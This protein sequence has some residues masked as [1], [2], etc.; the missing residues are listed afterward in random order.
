MDLEIPRTSAFTFQS[1]V[2]SLHVLRCLDD[3]RQKEILCDVT[4]LVEN[5]SYRAHRSV[6]AA[7]SDYFHNRVSGHAWQGL[8]ITLPE[9]VTVEGF[10]PLLQ[11]AYTAK[12]LFTKENIVEIH[13]CAEILGFHNLDKACF[14][15]LI[16]KFFD[17]GK[18]VH[19]VQRKVC[20]KTK[21]CKR[22][23]SQANSR[24]HS[25]RDEPEEEHS[26]AEPSRAVPKNRSDGAQT[27]S[28]VLVSE[29]PV[30]CVPGYPDTHAETDY[31][32]LCP[33]YRKF[34]VACEKDRFCLEDCGP[35]MTPFPPALTSQACASPCLPC[36]RGENN[37]GAGDVCS[38]PENETTPLANCL[39]CTPESSTST[40][41]LAT[42][43]LNC[44][45]PAGPSSAAPDRCP[46]GPADAVM[47]Q[48][49]D[50]ALGCAGNEGTV[51]FE[52]TDSALSVLGHE[53]GGDR[54]SVERE[55]AEHLAKGF[56][57]DPPPSQ[58]EPLL[59]DPES[60]SSLGKETDFHWLKHLDL[61]ASTGDCPFLRDLGEEVQLPEFEGGAQPEKSPCISSVNSGDNSDSDTDGDS[62]C[63][64]SER[65]RE[66]QLPFPVEQIP[67]LS[68]NDF[69]HMLR[70]QNL[71]REQ[72]DFVHDVRRRS[73]N[74]IAAQ[75]C[76]KR[77]LE[78][79]LGLEGEIHKLRSEKEKLVQE[80]DQLKRR[81]G[82]T[83]HSLSELCHK[84]CSEATL[85]PDQLEF[86]AQYSSP[87]CP[88]SVLITPTPSPALSLRFSLTLQDQDPTSAG[89]SLD[90]CPSEDP[91]PSA[92]ESRITPQSS[93]PS[94]PAL[95][96]PPPPPPVGT[97]DC[98]AP[99][100]NSSSPITDICLDVSG[101]CPASEVSQSRTP[102]PFDLNK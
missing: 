56:W 93:R 26:D 20:C 37:D 72:L 66:M 30:A 45:Q 12:L 67:S 89:I 33:K 51:N 102:L 17:H 85:S 44:D 4:I 78:C 11:F 96:P 39:S 8:V 58:G 19:R 80:R 2:H 75:R 76:R 90:A 28:S 84:V 46:V 54:S 98:S 40:G 27:Q 24:S 81:K 34:Q 3:Q 91:S 82:E 48:D 74:R 52:P 79:I 61:N 1:S 25:D 68:R 64:N 99:D 53:G 87:D 73:K 97:G 62:E 71:T 10:E 22:K 59:L 92:D 31:S 49:G 47:A 35:Q 83:L 86:L 101:Q 36:A 60:Q 16:P 38:V 69:Q 14:D 7:C 21:C 65:A 42:P 18:N 43:D 94:T 6:L 57:P 23:S 50:E 9:E 13:S 100:Q 29:S 88:A 41:F 63:Y 55:V 95:A 15:F 70:L 5:K 77:K 32:L